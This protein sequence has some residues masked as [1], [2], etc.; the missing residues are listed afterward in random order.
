MEGRGSWIGG[1]RA[2]DEEAAAKGRWGTGRGREGEVRI[3][4]VEEV[5]RRRCRRTAVESLV[6]T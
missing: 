5:V 4:L 2:V 6:G 3:D 1:F